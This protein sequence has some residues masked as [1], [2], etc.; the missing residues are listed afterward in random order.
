MARTKRRRNGGRDTVNSEPWKTFVAL[1]YFLLATWTTAIT[2]VI[3]HDRVPDMIVFPPL[4]G[5]YWLRVVAGHQNISAREYHSRT[6]DQL[7]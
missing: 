2:M 4:P 6:A 1:M 7:I 3:V 5:E